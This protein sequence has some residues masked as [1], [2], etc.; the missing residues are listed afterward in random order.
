MARKP[1]SNLTPGLFDERPVLSVTELTSNI[2]RTLESGYRNLMVQGEISNFKKYP[3]GHWYFTLKDELAQISCVFFRNWNRLL[4]FSLENGLEVQIR[5]NVT[6]WEKAGNY[7]LNVETIKPVGQGALQLA[8]EQLYRELEAEGLFNKARKRPLPL[9]PRRIGIVTSPTGAVIRDLMTVMGRRNPG[10]DI[11]LFPVRVQG[12]GAASEIAQAIRTLSE[13]HEQ[14]GI[15]V[16]IV[17]RGGGSIEDLWAFNEEIVARAI[18]DSR[19]PVVSAVGHET[20]FTIADFVADLRAATPSAAAELVA[21]D[22]SDLRAGVEQLSSNLGRAIDFY[23]L[24]RR[25]ELR[26]LIESRGFSRTIT[27]VGRMRSEV[28]ELELRTEHA[29]RQNLS[30]A[31][32]RFQ[33]ARKHLETIDWKAPLGVASGRLGAQVERLD[34]AMAAGLERQRHSM[35]LLG[36]KLNALSPLAV[37]HRGYTLVR[38]E[39]GQLISRSSEL[40][41]G[42]R[43]SLKFD[44]GEVGCEVIEKVMDKDGKRKED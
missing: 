10:L 12:T 20:D 40:E 34:R 19:I 14:L 3:S 18:Y 13:K 41:A 6:V 5:G 24:R 15:D 21:T 29:L 43:I 42:Q 9:L 17:G 27:A 11:L 35:Q 44:D 4:K 31:A 22:I 1:S 26:D 39:E 33:A 32:F 37:L 7:Q 28:R 30:R 38:G 2:K 8:F 25:N 16:M 36:G 23:L